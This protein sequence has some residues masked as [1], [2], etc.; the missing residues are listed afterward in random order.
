MVLRKIYLY[1]AGKLMKK[2]NQLG[3]HSLKCAIEL[4]QMTSGVTVSCS[5]CY[6]VSRSTENWVTTSATQGEPR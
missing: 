2:M 4:K 5:L 3:L 6:I 1:H